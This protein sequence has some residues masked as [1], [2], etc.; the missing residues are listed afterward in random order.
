MLAPG[1]RV[2]PPLALET[3]APSPRRTGQ[4]IPPVWVPM[5]LLQYCRVLAQPLA[6]E[7]AMCQCLRMTATRLFPLILGSMLAAGAGVARCHMMSIIYTKS[8]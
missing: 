1:A 8:S 5:D 4:S 3:L 2:R 6:S 7:D